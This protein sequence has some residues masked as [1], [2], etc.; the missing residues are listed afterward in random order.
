MEENIKV[1][2]ATEGE[3][4]AALALADFKFN[5][6]NP[7][8]GEIILE[9]AGPKIN[10]FAWL[11]RLENQ[12]RNVRGLLKSEFEMVA[13]EERAKGHVTSNTFYIEG[14]MG[15]IKVQFSKD[16]KL[17]KGRA[18]RYF[19]TDPSRAFEIMSASYKLSKREAEK[20]LR[21]IGGN[22]AL[23]ELIAEDLEKAPERA[24]VTFSQKG[25][26]DGE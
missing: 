24:A 20:I 18:A 4:V 6:V 1:E 19:S 12:V 2:T 17:D 15:S 11:E 21:T 13:N 10:A 25:T 8:T 23:K 22:E 16:M 26:P 5:L 3:E 7:R 9:Y 14:E